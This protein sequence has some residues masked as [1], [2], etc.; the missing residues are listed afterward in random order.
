MPASAHKF[1]DFELDPSRFELRRRG[2]ALKLERIPMELLLLLVEKQG[3]V[4]TRQEIID[5][6][7]GKEVFVDT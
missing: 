6:L 4:A 1:A 2:R 5:R 3:A 7:W